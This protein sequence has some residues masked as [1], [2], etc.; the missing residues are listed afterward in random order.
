MVSGMTLD[1]D[2]SSMPFCEGCVQGKQHRNAFLK[3]GGTRANKPLEIVHSDVCGPMRTT[4][5]GGSRYFL[6]FIDDF[7]RKVWLYTLK[8]K[9]E[10]LEKFKEFKALAE[11]Q[12]GHTIKAFRS[13]NGGEFISKAFRRFLKKHGIERQP[14]IPY[15]PEQNGVAERANRTIVEMARSMIHVQ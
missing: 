6:T 13:D 12:S 7:L 15:T 11:N 3:D 14:S 9:G 2:E 8:T 10:C 5:I 1:K 4:S